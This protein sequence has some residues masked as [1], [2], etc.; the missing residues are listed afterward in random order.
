MRAQSLGWLLI[1]LIFGGLLWCDGLFP[2][3]EDPRYPTNDD[4]WMYLAVASS[5]ADHGVLPYRDIASE[6]KTPFL[7]ILYRLAYERFGEMAPVA[8]QILGAIASGLTTIFL[9]LLGRDLYGERA[10]L[11]AAGA[12]TMAAGSEWV[13]ATPFVGTEVFAVCLACAGWLSLRRGYAHRSSLALLLAGLLLGGAFG[14]KQ[15]WALEILAATALIAFHWRM[16]LPAVAA[17]SAGLLATM[18]A[19][20]AYLARLGVLAD[21][22]QVCIVNPLTGTRGAVAWYERV[23]RLAHRLFSYVGMG[24]PWF[25]FGVLGLSRARSGWKEPRRDRLVLLYWTVSALLG[26][27]AAGKLFTYQLQ[28]FLAPLCLL[29]ALGL[30]AAWVLLLQLRDRRVAIAP[31]SVA[32]CGVAFMCLLTISP[33]VTA[34]LDMGAL[35]ISRLQRGG[36]VPRGVPEAKL[37]AAD[38]VQEHTDPSDEIFIWGQ[39]DYLYFLSGRKPGARHLNLIL[40][41]RSDAAKDSIIRELRADPPRLI[42]VEE[43]GALKQDSEFT[44]LDSLIAD[45]YEHAAAFP[46]LRLDCYLRQDDTSRRPGSAR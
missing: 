17:F 8:M 15:P 33:F 13:T 3:N 7:L 36:P 1:L 35:W 11:L 18:S 25:A 28:Q 5:W 37:S 20:T 39:A 41:A 4:T 30:D 38:F 42:I 46:S 45:R 29:A 40:A 19:I 12:W 23:Y 2:W 14:F 9:F 22:W 44:Q 24:A 34:Q 32:A 21:A 27:L 10:G 16:G 26:S 6:D 31:A 43:R